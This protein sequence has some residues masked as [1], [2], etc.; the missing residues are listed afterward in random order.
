MKSTYESKMESAI[1]NAYKGQN[2]FPV[3]ACFIRSCLESYDWNSSNKEKGNSL[4]MES[5]SGF[6]GK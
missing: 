4:I 2:K 3:K 6:L 5:S 1:L